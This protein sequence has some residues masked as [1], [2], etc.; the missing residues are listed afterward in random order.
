M[1]RIQQLCSIFLSFAFLTGCSGQEVPES[2]VKLTETQTTAFF[3]M[4]TVMELT[5]YCEPQLLEQAENRVEALE[6]LFSVTDEDSEIYIANHSGT[7]SLS[8]DSAMLLSEG[9]ALCQRT[10]GA[11]DLSIYPVM[12][13]WGFTADHCRVPE[14]DELSKLVSRVDY[15]Q[16]NFDPKKRSVALGAGMEIDLGSIA[17]GYAGDRL[18]EL[19]QNAGVSSAL[20]NLGGNIQV[21]GSKPDGSPWKIAIQNPAGDGNIGVRSAS[22]CAVITS[23][24]YERFFEEDGQIYWH[25]IDPSTGY[26]AHSGLTSVTVVGESGTLCDGLSTALLVMGKEAA[27]ALW[28]G[29]DDFEAVFVSED[30]SVAITEGLEASFSLTEDYAGASLSIIRRD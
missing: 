30:G 24:G 18:T 15:R 2:A 11:L 16:I 14:K 29:S 17:I 20:L 21:L 19:L 3:A 10:G 5:V 26:P 22:D 1:N 7:A 12:Q 4:D 13:A 28:R 8:E 25:I 23:G 6:A 9:L 27:A